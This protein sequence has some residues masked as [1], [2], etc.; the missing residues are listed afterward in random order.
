MSRIIR[1]SNATSDDRGFSTSLLRPGKYYIRER[2][3]VVRDASGDVRQSGGRPRTTNLSR[4]T[5]L[6]LA[7]PQWRDRSG[8]CDSSK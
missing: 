1:F 2:K 3:A 8:Q 6:T 5:W 4:L 7:L